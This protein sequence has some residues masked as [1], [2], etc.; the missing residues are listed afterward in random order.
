MTTQTLILEIPADLWQSSNQRLHHMERARRTKQVRTLAGLLG[1]QH[2]TPEPGPVHVMAFIAAPK[3]SRADVGN[4]YPTVKA[5]VDG[6]LTDAGI[7]PD[8]SDEHLI[9]PDMRRDPPTK[10]KGLYRVRLVITP[11]HVPF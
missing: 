2:L 5:C 1:R 9:G 10:T 6:A 8:D 4:T 7:I 3:A 11:Q